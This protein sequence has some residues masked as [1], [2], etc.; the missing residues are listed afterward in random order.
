MFW[1]FAAVVDLSARDGEGIEVEALMRARVSRHGSG[2]A[3]V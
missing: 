1:D 3:G 2:I